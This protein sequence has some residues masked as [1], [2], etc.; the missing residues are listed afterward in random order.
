MEEDSKERILSILN[1]CKNDEW[2]LAQ[3]MIESD[4]EKMIKEIKKEH[5]SSTIV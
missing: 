5:N 1:R 3:K 2:E 4:I